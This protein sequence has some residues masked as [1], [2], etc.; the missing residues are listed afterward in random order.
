MPVASLIP[1]QS[2]YARNFEHPVHAHAQKHARIHPAGYLIVGNTQVNVCWKHVR[3]AKLTRTSCAKVHTHMQWFMGHT[4]DPLGKV[5][6]QLSMN[7]IQKRIGFSRVY[8][9][10]H[11][12]VSEWSSTEVL[13]VTGQLCNRNS[14]KLFCVV[15]DHGDRDNVWKLVCPLQY[16]R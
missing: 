14:W 8:S 11:V 12:F 6:V 10:R 5:V 16:L 9:C 13:C 2:L 3:L 7:H 4:V 15:N 1:S